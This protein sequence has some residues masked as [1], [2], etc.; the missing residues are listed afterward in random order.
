MET[1]RGGAYW[2]AYR[3][4]RG[5]PAQGLSGQGRVAYARVPGRGGRRAGRV[6]SAMPERSAVMRRPSLARPQEPGPDVQMASMCAGHQ[7]G[8]EVRGFEPLRTRS[9]LCR[10][11]FPPGRL[12]PSGA[13]RSDAA[14]S[15]TGMP[16]FPRH[17]RVDVSGHERVRP[18]KLRSRPTRLGSQQLRLVRAVLLRSGTRDRCR[19]MPGLR[20]SPRSGRPWPSRPPVRGRCRPPPRCRP[21]RGRRSRAGDAPCAGPSC[22]GPPGASRRPRW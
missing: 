10:P 3:D 16:R 11:A 7:G 22:A 5:P 1:Q 4:D 9:P 18:A 14:A 12:G 19:S 17:V 2:V 21:G 8:V 20:K 13:R 15:E 6:Y